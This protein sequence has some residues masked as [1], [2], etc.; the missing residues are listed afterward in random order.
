MTQ[1]KTLF[2]ENNGIMYEA[3]IS[4]QEHS[5]YRVEYFANGKHVKTESINAT[6]LTQTESVVNNWFKNVRTLNG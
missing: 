6:S 3:R 2:N 4:K 5:P 1:V